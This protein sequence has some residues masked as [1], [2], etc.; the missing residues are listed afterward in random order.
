MKKLVAMLLSISMIACLFAGCGDGTSSAATSDQTSQPV[1]EESQKA[2]EQ[3]AIPAASETEPASEAETETSAVDES[4]IAQGPT[5]EWYSEHIGVKDY[6][7]PMFEDGLDLSIFWVQLGAMGGAEQPLKKDLLF[8]QR[9]Q[10]KLGVTLTFKQASEAVCNEQYNLMIASGDMTDLIYESNCGAMGATSV[11]NGGYDKAIEDDV[12][13]DLTDIIPEYAPNYYAILQSD[14][15]VRRDLTTDTGKLYSIA[16]IYDQPQGVREGPLVRADY[17]EATGMEEPVTT[18]DWMNVFEKMKNNGV[19]YPMGVSNSGDIRGGFFCNAFGTSGGHAFKVDLRTDELVYD[20]TSDE[21]RDFVEFFS[22]AF[23]AG[24]INPDYAYAQMFDDSL[25]T[26]GATALFGGMDRDLTNM[27]T[28]YGLDLKA[29]HMTYP[30]GSEAPKEYNYEYAKQRTS[31]MK[32]IVVTASCAEPEKAVQFLD[33]FYS[34][35]GASAVNFGFEEGESY[36]VVDGVKQMLPL[37]LERNEDL[38]SYQVIYA[39]DEGPGFQIVNKNNPINEDYV[40]EAKNIWLDYDTSKAL[41]SATPTLAFTA[42]EAE[43]M[44]QINS[45][46]Y[47]H[48]ATEI[49][50]FMMGESELNDDTWNAYVADVEAMGLAELQSFYEAAYSRYES[51]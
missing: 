28:N 46:I 36:Q 3:E 8:W 29:V 20:G 45:D 30:E 10:E 18:E 14:D 16:M 11:Y 7:L 33:W 23:K 49:S 47:T 13:V 34:T 38:V 35:E 19:Q 31:G 43:D 5:N 22:K 42:E 37:M 48:V 9:V 2:P 26:S 17:L 27:K 40:N 50:K 44:A 25:Q 6:D 21:L 51:R 39:L 1:A 24:Y 4:T 12:Y 32:N 15:N 41:F